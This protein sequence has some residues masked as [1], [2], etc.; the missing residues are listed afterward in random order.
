[1]SRPQAVQFVDIAGSV[2]IGERPKNRFGDVPHPDRLEPRRKDRQYW[3][4]ARHPGETIEEV[5][6]RTEHNR[7]AKDGGTRK[8]FGRRLSPSAFVRPYSAGK[9]ASAPIAES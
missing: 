4:D 9:S 1:M 6:L 2:A 7:R 8:R 5:V 3:H